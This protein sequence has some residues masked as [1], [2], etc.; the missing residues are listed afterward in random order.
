MTEHDNEIRTIYC[1]C[2][3]WEM[4]PSDMPRRKSQNFEHV[5]NTENNEAIY[6]CNC[7]L[8]TTSVCEISDSSEE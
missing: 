7:G 6:K 8:T 5:Q 2:G 3:E 4:F 1:D